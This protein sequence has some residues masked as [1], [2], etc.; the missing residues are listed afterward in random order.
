MQTEDSLIP[1]Y[2]ALHNMYDGLR[3]APLFMAIDEFDECS[4]GDTHRMKEGKIT[5]CQKNRQYC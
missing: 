1:L 4:L 2:E 5:I 3:K